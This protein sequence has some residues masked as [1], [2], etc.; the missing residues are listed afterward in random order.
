[1]QMYS[2][3]G[4][5]KI[6]QLLDRVTPE[7]TVASQVKPCIVFLRTTK[8]GSQYQCLVVVLARF[9]GWTMLIKAHIR[10]DGTIRYTYS[11]DS[12]ASL[13]RRKLPPL[14][15]KTQPYN[16]SL[17]LEFKH[18]FS[19]LSRLGDIHVMKSLNH[20]GKS[21]EECSVSLGVGPVNLFP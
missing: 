13:H 16:H 17:R 5:R 4:S 19:Y 21:H 15:A 6:S 7:S 10:V 18:S 9:L 8:E 20:V 11:D 1:M 12:I 3:D 14:D 2:N